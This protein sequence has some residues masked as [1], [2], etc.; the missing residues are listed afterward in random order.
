MKSLALETG[1]ANLAYWTRSL[2]RVCLPEGHSPP[3]EQCVHAWPAELWKPGV[4][5]TDASGGQHTS[6]PMLRR[7][8]F[9]CVQLQAPSCIDDGVLQLKPSMALAGPL[10][11]EKQAV[12]RGELAAVIACL[13]Q[14][15]PDGSTTTVIWTDSKYV[16]RGAGLPLTLCSL[17]LTV[18]CGSKWQ[19][20]ASV[21]KNAS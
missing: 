6:H 9:A 15:A 1:R 7:V 17:A 3:S 14:I 4:F 2:G 5:F 19:S 13:A 20:N 12:N 8:G 11:G 18:T 21:T 10:A 16:E